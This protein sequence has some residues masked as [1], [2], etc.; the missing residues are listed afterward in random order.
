M[1]SLRTEVPCFVGAVYGGLSPFPLVPADEAPDLDVADAAALR[2]QR[3]SQFVN[4]NLN[5]S[6]WL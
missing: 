6:K 4:A 2:S 3:E 5:V 1:Y